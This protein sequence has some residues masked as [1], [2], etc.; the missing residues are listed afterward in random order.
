MLIEDLLN[1]QPAMQVLANVK[2]PAKTSFR[3]A[4]ALKI[5]QPDLEA[6]EAVRL[7]T[8]QEFGTISK[9][10]KI[11][12]FATPELHASFQAA[13]KELQEEVVEPKFSM[14]S[15]DDLGDAEIEPS[16]LL[17]LFGILLSE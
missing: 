10:G 1:A 2:L 16:V 6:H 5:I 17:A 8:A 15:V 4:K 13:I 12:E 3:L 14:I 9:D 11:Y 7:K